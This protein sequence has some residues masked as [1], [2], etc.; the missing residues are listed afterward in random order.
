ML[1][2]VVYSVKC[3]DCGQLYIGKTE[4]QCIRRLQERELRRSARLKNKTTTTTTTTATTTTAINLDQAQTSSIEKHIIETGHNMDWR[5]FN[6]VCQGN[7][8]YR[9]LVKESLLI[10]A[11]QPE[12]NKTTHSIP[13]IVFPDGFSK[14]YL[15][16]PAK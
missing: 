3:K 16:D 14:T 10:Q 13:L 5:N 1:S 12:L 9:R 15:P 2:D 7:H 4:R 6:V 8:H 11:H